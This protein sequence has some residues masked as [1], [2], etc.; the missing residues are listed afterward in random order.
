VI[1]RLQ[2]AGRASLDLFH[3]DYRDSDKSEFPLDGLRHPLSQALF[4]LFPGQFSAWY[5]EWE[6]EDGGHVF[7]RDAAGS[8]VDLVSYPDLSCDDE[9]Y[10]AAEPV[11]WRPRRPTQR[12]LTLLAR[13]GFAL[14]AARSARVRRGHR[15]RRRAG[16]RRHD[17]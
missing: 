8:V 10:A 4:C 1:T 12:T 9:D 3:P 7:L 15:P 14:P 6:D 11:C 5:V 17:M 13:A 16:A 2:D